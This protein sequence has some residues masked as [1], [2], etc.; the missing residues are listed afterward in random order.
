MRELILGIACVCLTISQIALLTQH[1]DLIR[2]F[3]E[4][5]DIVQELRRIVEK[6]NDRNR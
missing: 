1:N 4:P 3:R 6:Q 5:I 2:R